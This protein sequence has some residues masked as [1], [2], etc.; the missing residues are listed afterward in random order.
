MATSVSTVTL[1]GLEPEAVLVEATLQRGLPAVHVVGLPDA[2]VRESVERV[3]GALRSAGQEFPRGRLTISLSPAEIKKTGAHFDLVIALAVLA[4]QGQMPNLQRSDGFLGQL[5]LDGSIRPVR[6]VLPLALGLLRQGTRRCFVSMPDARLLRHIP[7]LEVIAIKSLTELV[8]VLATG[9]IPTNRQ[10][11]DQSKPT[12]ERESE[13]TLD[14]LVGLHVAKRALIVAAAGGHNLLLV[15]PPGTGKTVLARCLPGLL[16]P[17]E[18]LEQREV[19]AIWSAAGFLHNW[20][21]QRP[22]RSPHHAASSVSLLGGGVPLQPG[23]V[24]LAHRGV[25]FLDELPEFRRDAIEQLRQPLEE[26]LVRVSR[27]GCRATFPARFLLVAAANPCPCGYLGDQLRACACGPAQVRRYQQKLS[28]PLLDRID[29]V[30]QVPR[31]SL[32]RIEA[33]G[34]SPALEEQRR[35][36]TAIKHA[37]QR[38]VVRNK[39]AKSNNLLNALLSSVQVRALVKLDTQARSLL[40]HAER[41]LGLSPRGYIRVLRVARTLADLAQRQNVVLDDVAEALQYR[42][43]FARS[44]KESS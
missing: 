12:S 1:L 18:P 31:S 21:T 3:R 11:P 23:D 36:L 43:E 28:G 2:A 29:I 24:S 27:A 5:G 22:Y 16:P 44:T 6:A 40:E 8:H 41:K 20:M 4:L 17:L 10:T 33:G 35:A 7:G 15:G 19:N 14:T 25:L 9:V 34:V 26:G 42:P 32:S 37:R 30:A 39:D 13:F 38:Q